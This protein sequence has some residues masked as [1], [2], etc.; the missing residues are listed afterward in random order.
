[1]RQQDYFLVL[2][3]HSENSP[4]HLNKILAKFTGLA[5]KH[6]FTMPSQGVDFFCESLESLRLTEVM[7]MWSGEGGVGRDSG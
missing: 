3:S 6:H 7:S 4:S 2:Y 5:I 1:M